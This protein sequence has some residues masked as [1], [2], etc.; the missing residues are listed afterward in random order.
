MAAVLLV[1][2][3]RS[4][5]NSSNNNNLLQERLGNHCKHQRLRLVSAPLVRR[6]SISIFWDCLR[7]SPQS[8]SANNANNAP[9][10]SIFGNPTPAAQPATGSFGVFGQ[11][12][13]QQQQQQ[14]QQQ[15]PNPLF[16]GGGGLFGNNNN[17]NNNQQQQGQQQQ[18]PS[19][20]CFFS[21]HSFI[22]SICIVLSV[23]GNAST[24]V[25][26]VVPPGGLFG[27][28]GGI[29]GN[30][31]NNQQQTQQQ[32][33]T[34]GFG[35]FGKPV[36]TT[37]PT[38]IFGNALGQP[39]NNNNAAPQST[40]LFGT[41]LGQTTN[42]NTGLF[43]RPNA[44]GIGQSTSAQQG[45]NSLFGNT[46]AQNGTLNATTSNQGA[47]GSLTASIA[48]PI[49]TNLPIFSMLPPGPRTFDTDA[50]QSKKKTGFFVDLPTRSPVP[51]VQLGYSPANTK[52]RGFASTASTSM[53]GGSNA[54]PF[55]SGL[56]F[57][58]NKQ[59]ALLMSRAGDN[60]ISISPDEF[61]G[62]SSSPSLGSGS[63]KSVKKLILD[64]KVEP[65]D[66]FTK[67]GS[68]PGGLR[69][70][71]ITFSPAL[72][73]AVREKDIAAAM[74]RA[75]QATASPTPAPRT[76]RAPNRF[77][78]ESSMASVL[79]YHPSNQ[80]SAPPEETKTLQDGDYWVKPD[81][82]TLKK[83]SFE[84]LSEFKD[85]V[86]GR[87]GYGEI[88]FLSPVDLTG[89]QKLSELLGQVVRFDDKECTVYPDSDDT[90]KP[91][92]GSGLNVRARVILERCWAVDKA[93]REPIK[94]E[95]NPSSIRMLKR[96]QNMKGTHY[97]SFDMKTGQWTFTV[98]HF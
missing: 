80:Q 58:T 70:G 50:L 71:K 73:V 14:P 27:G 22:F 43:G 52:L 69:G 15:Q 26:P 92:P 66:F 35:I 60:K 8:L 59:N 86:V 21:H 93:T 65:T 17:N 2:A 72:S 67:S 68:S 20:T 4:V 54:S 32:P 24:A 33:Q 91:P 30:N 98:D 64:K 40:S 6:E 34:G 48:Q 36:T 89:L 95:K 75:D 18:P 29:F 56:S 49:G 94:D 45:N 85:L 7:S 81:L 55:A 76:Q 38:S 79:D 13:N 3:E 74:S 11:A 25:Q 46:F 96:L 90:E 51:R 88:H 16:G 47:Q 19:R 63:R 9:K 61:L 57:S 10:T 39:P 53:L 84:E 42:Q 44:P 82:Q 97:E 62:R 12:Q 78:A 28:G 77:T 83:A 41:P 31:N 23:F 5:N 1:V 87:V 37:Q